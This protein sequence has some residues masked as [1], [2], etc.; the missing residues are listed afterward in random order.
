M[1]VLLTPEFSRVATKHDVS[2][3][4]LCEAV[5]RAEA[6]LID[7][8]LGGPLIKQRIPR[9]GQGRSRGFRAAAIYRAGNRFIFVHLFPKS[10]KANLSSVERDI[11]IKFG[12]MALMLSDEQL[13]A[14]V[15]QQ[16]WREL[17]CEQ[18]QEEVPE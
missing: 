14:L 9:P 8:S 15:A 5:E 11:Y 17:S 18:N 7:A 16:R 6:G 10:A 2:D 1:R 4:Q 12:K 13:D 3:S